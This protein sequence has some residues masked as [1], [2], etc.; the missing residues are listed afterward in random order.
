VA[1]V[2]GR[3]GFGHAIL[4]TRAL[5]R[6]RVAVAELVAS[7]ALVICI[8]IVVTAVTIDI[9]RTG[10]GAPSGKDGTLANFQFRNPA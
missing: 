6:G 10:C 5:R 1:T 9:A 2:S 3:V 7:A 4:A 8:L